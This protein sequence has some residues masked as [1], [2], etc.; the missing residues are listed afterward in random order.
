MDLTAL[1]RHRF[2]DKL[3]PTPIP[4]L[5]EVVPDV[6]RCS[7]IARIVS[8]DPNAKNA[9]REDA[10]RRLIDTRKNANGDVESAS[11]QFGMPDS[12]SYDTH[13]TIVWS[14]NGCQEPGLVRL[15]PG[16]GLVVLQKRRPR[17]N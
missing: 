1:K 17:G 4:R 15:F 9:K 11:E 7:R 10:M 2:R 13:A 8:N 3:L 16:G 14:P 12:V 6:H 5:F